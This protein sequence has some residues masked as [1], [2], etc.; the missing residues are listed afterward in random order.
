MSLKVAR[1]GQI[2]PFIVMDVLRAAN[3]RAAAGNSVLHLELG[4]PGSPA[5]AGVRAAAARALEQDAIGYTDALG[6][7]DLREAIARHY[8]ESYNVSVTAERVAATVGSSAGFLLTFL[9]A[10]EAGDRV[11]LAAPGYPAYRNILSAL[12]IE[13]VLLPTTLEHRYQPTP[14]LLDAAGPL[15]GLIV[16]SPSNPTG[17][18]LRRQE[19]AELVRWCDANG[20]RLVSDEIYHGISFGEPA[21]SALELTDQAVVVNSFSKYFCMT[22]WRLGW[23]VLPEELLRPVECLAQ[24]FFVSPP[25]LSQIA[26]IAAF[27]CHEELRAHVASYGRKRELLLNEL[28]KAGFEDIAPADGAFYLYADVA[29]MTNDSQELC[30]RILAETGVAITPGSDFDPDRGHRFVRLSFAASEADVAEAARR[31]TVWGR[32]R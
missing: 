28:P 21:V 5:P 16:A 11:A 2:P 10:F 15:D 22:G 1:R 20:V 27:D 30:R 26:A 6:L 29:R 3:E 13:P 23:L 31:L 19:M 24:N 32:G 8:K 9:A 4:Q 18:I 7:T 25:S 14:E 12:G 17:T